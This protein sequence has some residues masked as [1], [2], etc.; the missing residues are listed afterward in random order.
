MLV[1]SLLAAADA[2]SPDAQVADPFRSLNFRNLA[3]LADVMR[4]QVVAATNN[5]NVG[6]MI[7]SSCAFAGAAMGIFWAGRTLVPLNFLL[8][9]A[10]LAAVVAD[11]GLDT[12]FAI[13]HFQKALDPL[14]VRK[15]Y[16]EDLPLKRQ[17]ILQRIRR[18]PPAPKVAADDTAI[19]LYTSGTSGVP[20]GVCQTYRGLRSDIDAC[21]EKARLTDHHR[22]LGVLPLFHSF[23]LTAMLLVPIT[24]CAS[25]YYVPKFTP[26]GLFEIVRQQRSSITIMIASMYTAMLRAKQARA[27][28]LKTIEYAISG[29]EALPMTTFAFFKERV[30]VEILQGYGMTEASP[31]VSLNVPWA[32]KIGSVGQ[33]IPG[34]ETRSFDD[35]NNPLGVDQPGELWIRG[36]IVMKGYYRKAADTAAA[37]T[38]DGWYK[39]GDMAAIDADGY[40][41]ITGRK[42]EMIIVG[43]ENVYPREIEAVLDNHPAVAESAVVGQM[44][45]SRGEV[46]VAFVVPKDGQELTETALR[47]FCRDRVAGYKTPRRVIIARDL[48]RGPTGK[49]LKRK[50]VE[51]L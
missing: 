11:S 39:T 20:K 51:L 21:I 50:L 6:I 27:D 2:A 49:I 32:H 26:A 19:L 46:V 17:M 8:Q 23:G 3:R 1:E 43:G 44:D 18:M 47:E 34:I 40:I 12:I 14:P 10:E 25:V 4:R 30:N 41:T 7:P 48:P 16:I 28:D 29:G 37:I 45:P 5:S 31:V 42:K 22:F 36:P 35:A 13:R 15:I 38:P 9:P 24:L 33:P